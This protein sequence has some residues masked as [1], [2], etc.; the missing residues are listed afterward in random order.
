MTGCIAFCTR[1]ALAMVAFVSISIAETASEP[2]VSFRRDIVPLLRAN[3]VGCH[4][5][6]KSKGQLDLT[7]H[8]AIMKGGKNG[9]LMEGRDAHK[10]RLIE[11]ISGEEP[12]MPEEGEPLTEQEVGLIAQWITEGAGDDTLPGPDLHKLSVP[13]VYHSA[14]R[15][16]AL[17]WSPDGSLFAVSGFHEIL[18]RS[19][20]GAELVARLV[21]NSPQIEAISFSPDG[22]LLAAAGGAASEYGEIQ[23]WDVT[24]RTLLR[25]ILTTSDCVFGLS[26]SPDA[27]RVAVGCA[28]K[29]VRVFSITDG[30]EIMKCDNHI[31]WVFATAFSSDGAR[32]A[33]ASRDRAVKLIEV[34]TGNLIDDVNKARDPVLTL[35]R[36]PKSDE[37]AFADEKGGIRLHRMEPRG[38]RLAEGDDKENSFIR[39]CERMPGATPA[40][41]WSADGRLIA[42]GSSNGE[43]RIFTAADG[44]RAAT[45]KGSN[46][47]LFTVAFHPAGQEVAT[48]GS[49]GKVR[50][51]DA[52]TGALTRSFDPVPIATLAAE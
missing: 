18:L 50:I 30:R 44:K 39:E 4:K 20:D 16:S 37:V 17:S 52:K 38:G 23:I 26:F 19:G 22:K 40:L 51:F 15:I 11:D 29:T 43:A 46:A 25:S 12:A 34:A 31:D 33:S 45:L 49:D 14:P 35:V 2:G 32:L 8:A 42:A 13:P 41:A 6:G 3:C 9:A 28:D 27:T 7:S 21:G 10:S 1:L 24:T 47:A 5:P 36:N 48:G